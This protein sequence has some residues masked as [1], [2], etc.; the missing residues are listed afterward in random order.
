MSNSDYVTIYEPDE[1]SDSWT[2][3]GDLRA[4]GTGM[5][6][7]AN[8]DCRDFLELNFKHVYFDPESSCFY[9]YCKTADDANTLVSAINTWVTERR[10]RDSLAKSFNLSVKDADEII[11]LLTNPKRTDDFLLALDSTVRNIEP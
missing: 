3:S 7:D 9:A 5:E 6:D 11:D 1:Y 10:A 8:Y 4:P 2:I